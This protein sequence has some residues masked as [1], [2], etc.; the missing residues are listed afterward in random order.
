MGYKTRKSPILATLPFSD[1]NINRL[2]NAADP[3]AEVDR[4]SLRDDLADV[5]WEYLMQSPRDSQQSLKHQIEL[6][7]GAAG[8][9]EEL[10]RDK[11]D[12]VVHLI[13]GCN[14]T[15]SYKTW[16]EMIAA[17]GECRLQ[18]DSCVSNLEMMRDWLTGRFCELVRESQRI[19]GRTDLN[20]KLFHED[21]AGVF[22]K[23]FKVDKRAKGKAGISRDIFNK[24]DGPY[25]RF[26][27][28]FA[29]IAGVVKPDGRPYEKASI[30]EFIRGRAG[31]KR[32]RRSGQPSETT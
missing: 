26:A 12:L 2:I 4:E 24:V 15:Q 10:L 21:L 27:C 32:K 7:A 19:E 18:V 3:E 8:R 29:E 9:I 13:T 16:D 6:V 22:E 30:A 23:H 25:L 5:S 31:S 20:V 28:A 1:E 17:S 11:D 14:Y